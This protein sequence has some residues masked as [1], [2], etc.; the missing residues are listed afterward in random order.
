MSVKLSSQIS[1]GAGTHDVTVNNKIFP[2][3][4]ETVRILCDTSSGAVII[5]L[6]SITDFKSAL[7]AKII[8]EDVNDN[9]ATNNITINAATGNTI[10]NGSSLVISNNGEKAV[11]FIASKT[12]LAVLETGESLITASVQDAITAFAGGGQ[13]SATQLTKEY[14]RVTVVATDADSVKMPSA[15]VGKRVHIVNADEA[16]SLGI[17]PKTGELFEG[18]A[19]NAKVDLAFG[20]SLE[21]FCYVTGTWTLL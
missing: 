20:T 15:I 1:L 13:A 10:N 11:V 16:Q 2:T 18:L 4:N 14:N 19:A 6:P 3:G 8:I 21:A 9:A 17:Y 7:G 5:N 12:E